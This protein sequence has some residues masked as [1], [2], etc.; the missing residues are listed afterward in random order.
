MLIEL[1]HR[2]KRDETRQIVYVTISEINDQVYRFQ[3]GDVPIELDNNQAVLD[4]LNNRKKELHLFC[5]IK[6]YPGADI[7]EFLIEEKTKL[8]A[9]LD[10]EE[11]GCKNP[12][13][14]IIEN[15][16]YAGTHPLRYPPSEDL[17]QEA[18]TLL[19]EFSGTTFQELSDRIEG[20]LTSV[21]KVREYLIELSKAFLALI[22]FV[23]HS[24]S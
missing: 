14:I 6:T 17:L 4:H 15:H 16:T 7:S 12:D 24:S 19:G 22:F 21:P 2:E 20:D 1:N 8:E 5:L 23:D 13:G 11:A 9:F 18:L 3:V 10:W